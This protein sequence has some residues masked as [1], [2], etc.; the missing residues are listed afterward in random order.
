MKSWTNESKLLLDA[1]AKVEAVDEAVRQLKPY[2]RIDEQNWIIYVKLSEHLMDLYIR[3]GDDE[4]ATSVAT[5]NLIE[6]YQFGFFFLKYQV[7][8]N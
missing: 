3:K 7:S 6:N 4:K 1:A 5:D 2:S 8:N